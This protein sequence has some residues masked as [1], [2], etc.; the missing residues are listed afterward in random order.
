MKQKNKEKLAK[1]I[2]DYM[3]V[4]DVFHYLV[5]ENNNLIP[6]ETH[7]MFYPN[8]IS[9]QSL[10]FKHHINYKERYVTFFYQPLPKEVPNDIN[11]IYIPFGML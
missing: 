3:L 6:V 1:K 5:T 11:Y 9:V 7:Y 10:P 2:A 4:K 8:V